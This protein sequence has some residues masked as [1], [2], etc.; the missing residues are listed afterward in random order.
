MDRYC[1]QGNCRP[2]L[3]G[4][5]CQVSDQRTMKRIGLNARSMHGP[6]PDTRGA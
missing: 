2:V 3:S 5:Q 1:F 4:G 6:R